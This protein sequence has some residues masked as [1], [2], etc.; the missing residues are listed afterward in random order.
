MSSIFRLN[1]EGNQIVQNIFL[2]HRDVFK[3]MSLNSFFCNYSLRKIKV[4]LSLMPVG[5]HVSNVLCNLTIGPSLS[6][7]QEEIE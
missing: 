5:Q 7:N 6:L 2:V 1:V 4:N 3:N